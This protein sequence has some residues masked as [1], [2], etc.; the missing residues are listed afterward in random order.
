MGE[1]LGKNVAAPIRFLTPQKGEEQ[2]REQ[3]TRQCPGCPEL[4]VD[5]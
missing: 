1:A 2:D 5:V 3:G 4:Q